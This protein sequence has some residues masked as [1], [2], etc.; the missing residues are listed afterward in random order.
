MSLSTALSKMEMDG[1]FKYENLS[2]LCQA[3]GVEEPSTKEEAISSMKAFY[4]DASN[5][6]SAY[7]SLPPFESDIINAHVQSGCCIDAKAVNALAEKHGVKNV[8]KMYFVTPIELF[9]NHLQGSALS[10]VF[11]PYG[12]MPKEIFDV[13]KKIT[14]PLKAVFSEYEPTSD[15]VTIEREGRVSDIAF[16]A[17]YINKTSPPVTANGMVT[18]QHALKFAAACGYKDLCQSGATSIASAR[19]TSQMII[20][21]SMLILALASKLIAADSGSA[22]IG[23]GASKVLSLP[24]AE[25]AKHIFEAYEDAASFSELSCIKGLKAKSKR[26]KFPE[27]RKEARLILSNCPSGRYIKFKEFEEY[28]YKANRM[29]ARRHIGAVVKNYGYEVGWE[30]FESKYL[31]VYLSL[32]C[33]LGMADTIWC[34]RASDYSGESEAYIEAFR[35]TSSG[36]FVLGIA[37]GSPMSAN[38][39]YEPK[40]GFVVQPNFEILVEESESRA[41]HDLYFSRFLDKIV[42]DDAISAYTLSFE[43]MARGLDSGIS[44]EEVATY[45]AKYSSK[46]LPSNV[47]RQ[48]QDWSRLSGRIAVRKVLVIE[49]DDEYLLEEIKTMKGVSDLLGKQLGPSCVI[50][51]SDVGKLKKAIEKNGKF[52]MEEL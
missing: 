2:L 7:L 32:L 50:A 40:N 39:D 34:T 4:K 15:C 33:A 45:L 52:C 21:S 8:S 36:A 47:S 44:I 27:A 30:A 25:M 19:S 3:A 23:P 16:L 26:A 41:A 37:G 49:A 29:F 14:P 10:L 5:I 9:F 17:R 48:L 38:E 51:P 12:A 20:T 11:F 13:M 24:N 46:P 28:A 42:E 35:L 1:Y 43:G 18:K 31:T 22:Y 6:K